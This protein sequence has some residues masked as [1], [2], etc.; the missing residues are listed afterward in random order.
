MW[1][2]KLAKRITFAYGN[3]AR[4]EASRPARGSGC[5]GTRSPTAAISRSNASS[6]AATADSPLRYNL[7]PRSFTPLMEEICNGPIPH[8]FKARPI[9]RKFLAIQ[10]QSLINLKKKSRTLDIYLL[11]NF[12][13]LW[14]RLSWI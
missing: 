2:L 7:F 11:Y 4:C 3:G 13:T 9:W 8:Y 1:R 10:N 12:A 6:T 5:S 14:R